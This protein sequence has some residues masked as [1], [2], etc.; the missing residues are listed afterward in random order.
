MGKSK[1]YK[2]TTDYITNFLPK[3]N[4]V[5]F[6][7]TDHNEIVYKS[8]EG[9]MVGK[10][11]T[12]VIRNLVKGK[13]V[14]FDDIVTQY[15]A[16][17]HFF[18]DFGFYP[19]NKDA[20]GSP[21]PENMLNIWNGFQGRFV[22]YDIKVIEP[23]LHHIKTCWANDNENIYNYIL[24]WLAHIVQFPYKKT[25]ILIILYSS[26]QQVGKNI[27]TNFFIDYVFGQ[28]LSY[29][30][31]GTDN[32]TCRFNTNIYRKVFVNCNELSSIDGTERNT[33]FDLLKNLITEDYMDF[34][35]KGGRK[36]KG[37]NYMNILATTN[38]TF[39]Y[40]IEDGDA[41]ILPLKVSNRYAQNFAYFKRLGES[42]NQNTGNHF[43]SF[44]K[45]RDLRDVVLTNIPM[46]DLKEDMIEHSLPS[47]IRFL[48]YVKEDKE[49]LMNK[50]GRD[51]DWKGVKSKD[52]FQVYYNWCTENNEKKM[53]NTAFGKIVN[54]KY[55]K[56]RT[57]NGYMYDLEG[58]KN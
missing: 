32:L 28:E 4:Q 19:N 47:P 9:Y 5:F 25:R 14:K 17:I 45:E 27:L 16:H 18:H 21:C 57:N 48:N 22:D 8:R 44:L 38:H 11:N 3:Y 39:T 10:P 30:M 53:S 41:R 15:T 42:L 56:R 7:F 35:I 46:T 36:W 49:Y 23:I 1:A 52:L 58:L 40:K 55:E 51:I 31:A 20:N 2:K 24:D 43:I 54:T 26:L 33:Q 29:A 13:V 6:H 50:I 12:T 37:D 34:E